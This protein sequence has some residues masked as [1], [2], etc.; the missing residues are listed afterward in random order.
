M[1]W[2]NLSQEHPHQMMHH[3]YIVWNLID[4]LKL[5][6]DVYHDLQLLFLLFLLL[7]YFLKFALE[8]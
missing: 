2:T 8:T 7:F 4:I 5:N 1:A 3:N 6:F